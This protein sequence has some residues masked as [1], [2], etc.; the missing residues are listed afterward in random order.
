M[1]EYSSDALIEAF[2]DLDIKSLARH[3]P[4]PKRSRIVW[5]AKPEKIPQTGER[6]RKGSEYATQH[7]MK[8]EAD[9]SAVRTFGI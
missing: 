7:V 3:A 9:L 8:L 4:P 6:E 5:N 1:T 2:F